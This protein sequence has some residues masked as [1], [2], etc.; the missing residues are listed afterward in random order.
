MLAALLSNGIVVP[1]AFA[2]DAVVESLIQ[3]GIQLRRDGQDEQ[4]INV[5]LDAERQEPRSVR[6]LLHILTAAQAA[7]RWLM[8]DAYMQKVSALKDDPYYQRHEDAIEVVR[9]AI[10]GRVGTFQVQGSPEGATVRLDG[11]QIA[12][13]PMKLPTSVE[14]GS[15]VMEVQSQGYYRLRRNVTITGGVLTREPVELNRVPPPREDVAAGA[16]PGGGSAAS[17]ATPEERSWWASPAVGWSL[18]GVGVASGVMSGIAFGMREDRAQTWNSESECIPS[19]GQTREEACG[20]FKD[21][22]E[23]YQTVGVI[24]AIASVAFVGTGLTL[25]LTGASDNSNGA[26]QSNGS[27]ATGG[28]LQLTSCGAGLMSIACRGSF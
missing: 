18:F 26:L 7:G 6:V 14:A 17:A 11:R 20:N 22:A 19:T 28:G 23:T 13:L 16:E 2:E 21:D 9:R 8:A 15:Y 1:Q 25:L 3:R 12:T 24:T 10:A 27:A 4:A 5:F